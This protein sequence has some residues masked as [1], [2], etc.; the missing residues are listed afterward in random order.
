M[1]LYRAVL[2][3]NNAKS[4]RLLGVGAGFTSVPPLALP[5]YTATPCCLKNTASRLTGI[6]VV[7]L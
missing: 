2:T 1:S 3:G 6:P 4:N 7:K 5:L